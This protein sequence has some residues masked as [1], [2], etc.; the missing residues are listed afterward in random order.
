M[1][2]NHTGGSYGAADGKDLTILASGLNHVDSIS[3]TGAVKIGGSG[4]L[5]VDNM[6]D[7]TLANLELMPLE[8][9]A[10]EE[11]GYIAPELR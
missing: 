8:N 1:M 9:K 7:A 11:Y 5:L 6:D 10:K 4:I 2:V 3:G